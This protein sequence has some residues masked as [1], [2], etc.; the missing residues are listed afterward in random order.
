[1]GL[2]FGNDPVVEV[3]RYTGGNIDHFAGCNMH[4]GLIQTNIV[5]VHTPLLTELFQ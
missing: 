3:E 1:M 5:M 4:Q 2:C